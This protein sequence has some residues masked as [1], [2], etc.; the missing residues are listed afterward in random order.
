MPSN[1]DRL[2]RAAAAIQKR[3]DA[4]RDPAIARQNLTPR[5][6]RIAAG[7]E[8]EAA[9]LEAVQRVLLHLAHLAE[10]DQTPA[11]LAKVT[12]AAAVALL[13]SWGPNGKLPSTE[14][15]VSESRAKL[16]RL[17]I[18]SDGKL[19]EAW[20]AVEAV[21]KQRREPTA[22][23]RVRELE[24]GLLG[25]RIPGF[26]PT[27]APLADRVVAAAGVTDEHLVLEPSA[28]KG[29]LVAA[30][31]RA[32]PSAQVV[33]VEIAHT[34][35]KL[36]ETRFLVRSGQVSLRPG[37]FL[38]IAPEA[39]Y[40]RV[41]MN[42]PF[43]RG[44]D[45]EHVLHALRFL[46]RGGRLVAIMSG[47]AL[48]GRGAEAFHAALDHAC[49]DLWSAEPLPEGSFQGSEAFRQTGVRALLLITEVS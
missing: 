20:A 37:D 15:W 33:A 14:G 34:L 29:D 12:S 38:E 28:G 46:R 5:R 49:G 19:G 31:L 18:D 2:R 36:L 11:P 44:A 25:T 47:A 21:Y 48:E 30:V 3:I 1:A 6:A 32:A 24:R 23:E 22:A 41:I 13:A 17:G 43:E 35:Q 16:A 8:R 42:P 10:L 26:F 9:S 7:M 4:K 40:D 45:R 39:A 27:P